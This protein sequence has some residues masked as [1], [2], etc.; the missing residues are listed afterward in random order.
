MQVKYTQNTS[1]LNQEVFII[2]SF[3]V[4]N[5]YKDILHTFYKFRSFCWISYFHNPIDVSCL[6]TIS[7]SSILILKCANANLLYISRNLNRF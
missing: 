6:Y 7:F 5:L 2:L 4:H 3:I 1:R